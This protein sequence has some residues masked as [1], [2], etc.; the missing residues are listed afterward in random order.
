VP[1]LDGV[2]DGDLCLLRVAKPD[3]V[4][5]LALQGREERLAHL[6]VVGISYPFHRQA[7]ARLSSPIAERNRGVPA[8]LIR[9]ID[10]GGG[11][12]RL[13]AISGAAKTQF[14]PQMQCE[15]LPNHP[16]APGTQDYCDVQEP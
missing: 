8:G 10:D 16:S 14:H 11:G 2:E 4:D 3:V 7:D 1:P 5:E 12:R 13:P 9:V 6:A 15:G